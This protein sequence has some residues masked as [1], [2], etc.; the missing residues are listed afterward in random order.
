MW[1]HIVCVS[2]LLHYV[3][4]QSGTTLNIKDV[5]E[6]RC[7][8]YKETLYNGLL[9]EVKASCGDLWLKFLDA[10]AYK[11]PC[12]VKFESYSAYWEA[13]KQILPTDK[14]MF[15]SGVYNLAHRFANNGKRYVTLEDTL[16]GYLANSLTW[17]GTQKQ[18]GLNFTRCPSW[19]DCPTEASESFWAG[20]S[21]TFASEAK[22]VVTLMLDG[23]N[24]KQ[25]AYRRNSFFAKYE[26]PSL[27]PKLVTSVKVI[28]THALNAPKVEF[29]GTGSLVD[30]KNDVTKAG[31]KYTC[32][33]DPIAVMHLLCADDPESRECQLTFAHAQGELTRKKRSEDFNG[34]PDFF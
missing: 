32:T 20:A 24:P 25:P 1:S 23:S 3:T 10:F 6:G 16:I 26:L 31:L 13:A 17:C 33:D 2:V 4:G 22:G 15:W 7:Y 11:H 34:M 9:P 29:C 14:V 19:T 21:K 18:P 28:V 27:N 12:D 30:L 5:F 8:D